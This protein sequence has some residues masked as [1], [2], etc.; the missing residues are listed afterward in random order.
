MESKFK[1]GELVY[2]YDD[3]TKHPYMIHDVFGKQVS[4]GL[5]EYPDVEQDDYIDISDVIKF[6][7][8]ELLVAKEIIDD[9]LN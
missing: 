3:D 7:K 5:M 4:L 2:M 6:T 9:L 8:S 1:V